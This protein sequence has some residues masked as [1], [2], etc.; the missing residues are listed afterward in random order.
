[1]TQNFDCGAI[2]LGSWLFFQTFRLQPSV[3]SAFYHSPMSV[4]STS[5]INLT[6]QESSRVSAALQLVVSSPGILVLTL[7]REVNGDIWNHS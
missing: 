3:M 2:V 4:L 7:I 6:A 1:M 5:A